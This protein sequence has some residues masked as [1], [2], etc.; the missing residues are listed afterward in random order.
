M[1]AL[2]RLAGTWQI[3]GDATGTVRY[4]WLPGRFFLTGAW[5]GP[6]GGYQTTSTR[7]PRPPSKPGIDTA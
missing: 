4:R 1:Q 6:G 3:S 7:R 5:A 2:D